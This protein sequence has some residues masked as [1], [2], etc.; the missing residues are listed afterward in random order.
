MQTILPVNKLVGTML[1][2]Y[3]IERLLN[4][5]TLGTVYIA[6]KNGQ[7]ESVMVTLFSLP[8]KF[9]DQARKIFWARFHH[10]GQKLIKLRHPHILPLHTY[11]Q[12]ASYPYII[13][14]FVKGRSLAQILK[15]QPL[16]TPQQT[17]NVLKQVAVGLDYIHNSGIVHGLLNPTSL[18]VDNFQTVQL[19]G[20]GL[21]PILEMYGIERS[22]H[23][24]AHLYSIAETF[25][26]APEYLAPE[27]ARS[28]PV[29]ARTDIYSLGIILFE[30]LTGTR[31]FTG[32][33]KFEVVLQRLQ[34][35]VPSLRTVFPN[36]PGRLD[37]VIQKA[38][39]RHPSQRFQTVNEFAQA[40]EQALQGQEVHE[41][42]GA[43]DA[44]NPSAA[45]HND[46]TLPPTV[47]WFAEETPVDISAH[48]VPTTTMSYLSSIEPAS[49]RMP[50]QPRQTPEPS[51][52]GHTMA[53]HRL[54]DNAQ[55]PARVIGGDP[56]DM[57]SVSSAKPE[58]QT[59]IHRKQP[60]PAQN[61]PRQKAAA[62]PPLTQQSSKTASIS[63]DKQQ[64]SKTASISL[65]K[66][67]SSKTAS[68]SPD[69]QQSS[70]TASISPD[71]QKR[72]STP[73]PGRRKVVALLAAGSVGVVAV[74]GLGFGGMNLARTLHL[75]Q[76]TQTTTTKKAPPSAKK[77]TKST[78]PATHTGTV[79]GTTTLAKNSSKEFT[80]PADGQ[81]SMLIHLADG[82]FVAAER[83]CTHQ[84]VPV[85][86][87]S[88]TGKLV[89]PLHGSIF[90]PANNFAVLQGPAMTPLKPVTIKVNS[91]G[92]IT[93]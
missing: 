33:D 79:I 85:N 39:Q 38:L 83:A 82:T 86:Y 24:Y 56:F 90:D 88:A 26:G 31:P 58:A 93:V 5:G 3:Q 25:L 35:P 46:M 77:S 10:E 23:P 84:G 53:F 72:K 12:Y 89:C 32:T 57:W 80:N 92:T 8:E 91:D 69:K 28:E 41:Q 67:Q 60:S 19:G 55:K 6:R 61:Q 63:L 65:N 74:A 15:Q 87:H 44:V 66:Q 20:I 9:P 27:C 29:D 7:K 14:S 42:I 21:R 47:D 11:G 2:E 43:R 36:A 13:S 37:Q 18:L 16:F 48:G 51:P 50:A 76:S 45:L 52:E 75:N 73:K 59:T 70:K 62:I 71:K 78:Q 17:L 49:V 1:G 54:S 30:M 68:I 34:S 64:S 40:F 22:N 4:H 81:Q